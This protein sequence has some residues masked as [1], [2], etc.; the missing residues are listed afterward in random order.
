MP[1]DI[2]AYIDLTK[3]VTFGEL[4]EFVQAGAAIGVGPDEH[5][6]TAFG[7]GD[8][9]SHHDFSGL[10]L[11]GSAQALTTG[12]GPLLLDRQR[13]DQLITM[14]DAIIDREGDARPDLSETH[15]LRAYLYSLIAAV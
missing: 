6:D 11:Y 3:P 8:D 4:Q 5:V 9:Q 13:V 12:G 7:E 1:T 14:F 2:T 10:R 15:E